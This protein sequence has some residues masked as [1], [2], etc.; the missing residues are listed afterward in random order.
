[1]KASLIPSLC[2]ALSLF[3]FALPFQASAEEVKLPVGQQAAE[4]QALARPTQGMNKD[5]VEARFGSPM[6]LHGAVGDP[7]ISAW[8]YSDFVVYF[9]RDL[10]LHTVL[11]DD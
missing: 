5:Q 4:K 7:P 2:L 11:K 9:E 3:T 1:M 10:V 6:T 8:E